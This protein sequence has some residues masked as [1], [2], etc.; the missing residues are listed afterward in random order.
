ML[1]SWG[2]PIVTAA[3]TIG[4]SLAITVAQTVDE[5]LTPSL[6]TQGAVIV[7]GV[8]VFLYQERKMR[9]EAEASASMRR[10]SDDRASR[11][12]AELEQRIEQM[13]VEHAAEV[14]ALNQ[15]II[16]ALRSD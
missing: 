15:R 7:A 5:G 13:L 12:I 6:W 1:S 14:R 8:S 16:D 3:A 10:E 9:R 11:R 2:D 4:A